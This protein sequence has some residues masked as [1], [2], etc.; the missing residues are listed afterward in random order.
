MRPKVSVSPAW[1][2]SAGA[3]L[4]ATPE[5]AGYIPDERSPTAYCVRHGG[6]V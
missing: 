5:R 4:Y 1:D 2:F 6:A 3:K